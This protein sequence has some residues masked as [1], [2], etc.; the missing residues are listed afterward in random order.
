MSGYG[1]NL[2][3]LRKYAVIIYVLIITSASL[4]TCTGKAYAAA[5][6]SDIRVLLSADSS[7]TI[8]ITA[9]GDFYI[10]ENTDF[11]LASDEISITVAGDRPV[12]KSGENVFTASSITFINRDYNGTSSYI[13]FKH[14][15][16]GICTYLGNMELTVREGKIRIINTLPTERYLYGVVPYEMS[17]TF[18]VESLKAQAVCARGYALANCSKYRDRDYDILDT[19]SD[20]VYHGY[21]SKYTR[22]IAAVDET[23]GQV[24][25]Y[26]GDI[27]QAYY[28][29]SNGG[30][31]ELTG[32]VWKESLP[33]YVQRDDP[34]DTEN[35][36][37]LEDKSFIPAQF[38]DETRKLM[39]TLVLNML[40]EK[41]NYAAGGEVTLVSTVR[42][43]A[44]DPIYEPPSRRYK[45]AD[46]V[47]MVSSADGSRNGQVT[48]TLFFEDLLYSKDNPKGIFN[49]AN[50]T[51]RL[52]G[53]E[54]GAVFVDEKQYEGWFLTNRRYGHGVGLSQR[55][56]QQRATVGQSYT[57]IVSFYYADTAL[58]TKGTYEAAPKLKSKKYT[59][60]ES[61]INGVT[62]GT[63]ADKFL[64]GISSAGGD[65]SVISYRGEKKTD[66]KIV[67][68]DFLRTEYD[69]G[70]SIFDIPLLIY[71]D[72]SG[73]GKIDESDLDALR[74]HFMNTDKLTGA[75]L[76]AA[77]VN[78][79][80]SVDSTDV[81][82]LL[83]HIQHAGT[84]KQG[85]KSG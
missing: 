15:S 32:N 27:I 41:A 48:V 46:V 71:G 44:Y 35:P 60:S 43:L 85:G 73:D 69:G 84:I 77:D 28:T 49:T 66:G 24:L 63:T 11:R 56:A 47:I 70:A 23:Y 6:Y 10:S 7:K 78:R 67:T 82:K 3:K 72:L 9:V 68:G 25:T 33:Y 13:R 80:G 38:N 30:Q 65:I 4:F 1:V 64:S 61:H 55:G 8:K 22:A 31:T 16:Y 5:F 76:S 37:S 54:T 79:D 62:P 42:I 12:L 50:T 21:A 34:F 20:Q 19:S 57:Q 36:F 75:Y 52:R 29:A 26:E 58:C 17:N 45:K 18:P 40:Q 59:I 81:L 74:K 2:G 14:P 53:A 39:D 51:L 83:K